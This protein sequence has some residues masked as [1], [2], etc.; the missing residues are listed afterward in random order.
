MSI[1]TIH[2]NPRRARNRL[3]LTGQA[4]AGW[5]CESEAYVYGGKVYWNVVAKCGAKKQLQ[6]TSRKQWAPCRCERCRA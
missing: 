2:L 1:E 6:I 5:R 3:D 4:F